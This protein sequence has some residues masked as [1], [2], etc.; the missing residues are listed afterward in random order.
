MASEFTSINHYV[1]QWYQH[2]FIPA[3]QKER[4]YHYLDLLPE[5]ISRPN[6]TFHFRNERRLLGPINC[7][8]QEHLYTLLFGEYATDVIEKRFFGAIDNRGAG[9]VEFFSNYEISEKTEDS[10]HNLLQYLDAQKL[11]TPKGLDLLRKLKHGA[12]H[13]H[14]LALMQHLWQVHVTIWMECVWEVLECDNSPT[15]FIVT[16]HPVTTYNKGLFPLSSSCTYPLDA[17]IEMLGT[18]TLF[19][20]SLNRCLVLTNLGY[21]RDP[22][23]NP[24][25]TREN[26]RSFAPTIFDMRHVQTGR[27]IAEDEVR[28]INFI[29]KKRARRFIAAAELDWLYP[30]K[31]LRSTM[32]N[33]L[34]DQFFLMPDARKVTFSTDI[35]IGYK[36]GGAWG[37]DE[38]GRRP[39]RTD[40]E[41]KRLREKEW[42]TFHRHQQLWEAKF[43][44][45]TREEM[46]RYW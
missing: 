32:W 19:P 1:P 15:K 17:P 34:G 43:G 39:K 20:L 14:A 11:R 45:L 35:L 27:Q 25:R 36:D 28:A 21:V 44:K 41:V 38:Y 16:D 12:T 3:R 4:K 22:W 10:T 23:A 9:A 24:T 30:E 33:K 5:R 37:M 40:D 18:H 6:G 29:L 26:A 46:L 8:H 2:R 7:F 31:H 13:A 42:K